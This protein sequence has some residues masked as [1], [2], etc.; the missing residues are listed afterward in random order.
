MPYKDRGFQWELPSDLI[1][2]AKLQAYITCIYT[3]RV[4]PCREV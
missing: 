4:I 2:A 3:F 1:E